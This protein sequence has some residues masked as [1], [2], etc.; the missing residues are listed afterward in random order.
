MAK[1]LKIAGDLAIEVTQRCN[2]NCDHCLR[3]CSRNKNISYEV[4]D[5]ILDNYAHISSILFTGGEPTLNVEAISYT[6]DQIK[7]RGISV[8]C[9]YVVTNGVQFSKELVW[10]LLEFYA[11][12]SE[13]D[14]CGLCISVD[15]FHQNLSQEAYDMYSGLAFFRNDKEHSN[16][17]DG[18]IINRGN[19]MEYGLG[20]FDKS[21]GE[22]S[23]DCAEMWDDHIQYD[24]ILYV[25][26]DGWV[27]F[28]CDL[29]YDMQDKNHTI[30]VKDDSI[31]EWMFA[32]MYENDCLSYEPSADE[33]AEYGLMPV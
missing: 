29:S 20:T 3:G 9:F 5:K 26:V 12:C 6:I 23:P 14:F 24:N 16:G 17:W 27:F 2:L 30:N 33:L 7:K 28:D 18:E 15:E 32:E 8:G 25:N 21:I 4:I 13:K 31:A 10:K 19:A 22:F 1:K 11:Y